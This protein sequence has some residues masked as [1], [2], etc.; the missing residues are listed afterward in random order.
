MVPLEL[1]L[2]EEDKL[3]VIIFVKLPEIPDMLSIKAVPSMCKSLN[4]WLGAPISKTSSVE[5]KIE[6]EIV[7]LWLIKGILTLSAKAVKDKVPIVAVPCTCKSFQEFAA[8]PRLKILSAYGN[9]LELTN[10]MDALSIEAK[11]IF[12]VPSMNKSFHSLVEEPKS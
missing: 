4:S 8:V 10:P 2:P 3:V 6:P 7:I 9:K 5:G 11:S 1:I 12:A